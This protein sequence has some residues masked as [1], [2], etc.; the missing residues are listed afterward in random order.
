MLLLSLSCRD[1]FVRLGPRL[2]ALDRQNLTGPYSLDLSSDIHRAVAWRL[3]LAALQDNSTSECRC[4][5]LV[6]STGQLDGH[7]PAAQS[8]IGCP[9]S[10]CSRPACQAGCGGW[11]TLA[12]TLGRLVAGCGHLASC[13]HLAMLHH[14]GT[15]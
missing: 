2:M 10:C 5:Q 3:Q 9:Q 14:A 15:V 4:V 11:W 7:C 1:S 12:E 6:I 8:S 13:D